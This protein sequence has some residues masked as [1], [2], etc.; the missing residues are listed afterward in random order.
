MQ[1]GPLEWE[2]AG[3]ITLHELFDKINEDVEAFL[4]AER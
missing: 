2:G 3:F 1:A 4:Q